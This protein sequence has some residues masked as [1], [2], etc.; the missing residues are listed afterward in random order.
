M[1]AFLWLEPLCKGVASGHRSCSSLHTE[2]GAALVGQVPCHPPKV[3]LLSDLTPKAGE[4]REAARTLRSRFAW[5]EVG[6]VQSG[7]FSL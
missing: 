6:G 1:V 2:S 7:N 5:S 3:L 4:K